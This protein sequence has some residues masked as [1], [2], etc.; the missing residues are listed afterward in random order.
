MDILNG[1]T[2]VYELETG[3]ANGILDFR[4]DGT[5]T[6][7]PRPEFV[8]FYGFE[9]FTYRISGTQNVAG[10]DLPVR[11][12]RAATVTINVRPVNDSPFANDF[13]F[14][15]SEPTDTN[16]NT[17]VTILAGASDQP[18]T[19][20]F[21]AVPH[22]NTTELPPWNE[23]EQQLAV[24]QITVTSSTG[25][26]VDVVDLNQPGPYVQDAFVFNPTGGNFVRIGSVTANVD[27]LSGSV[28]SVVFQPDDHYNEINPA[29]ANL[30]VDAFRFT[31]SDDGASTLPSGDPA[32]PQPAP[33]SY[34]ATA[35]VRVTP[36]NDRPTAGDDTYL[37]V[38]EDT[39]YDILLRNAGS[40]ILDNDLA[41]SL[42]NDDESG[43][44][45]DLVPG[46]PAGAIVNVDIGVLGSGV[47][48]QAGLSGTGYVMYSTTN[49][50]ARFGSNAPPNTVNAVAASHLLAVRFSNN[51]WQY[52]DGTIWH[53]FTPQPRV[54]GSANVPEFPGDRLIAQIDFDNNPLIPNDY[55]FTEFL[56]DSG[57]I[58]GIEL[59]YVADNLTITPQ[60]WNGL[61]HPSNFTIQAPTGEPAN[62][63]YVSD[64]TFPTTFFYDIPIVPPV[65]PSTPLP[66][67]GLKTDKGG[68]VFFSD[69][70]GKLIYRPPTDYYGPDSFEYFITDNDPTQP[71]FDSGRVSL[72]VNPVNDLPFAMDHSFTTQE[73]TQIGELITAAD[74]I[75]GARGHA[76]PQ[77]GEPDPND[78]TTIITQPWDE[79]N[80]DFDPS[81]PTPDN[82]YRVA[83]LVGVT[84][85]NGVLTTALG[86]EVRDV[87]R[88]ASDGSILDFRYFPPTDF[89]VDNPINGQDQDTFGY[90]LVDSGISE[91]LDGSTTAGSPRSA[92]GSI[93]VSVEPQNDEPAAADDFISDNPNGSWDRFFALQSQ[94]APGLLEEGQLLIPA[95]F[96]LANDAQARSTAG[97]ELAQI[98]DGQ[99]SIV[100]MTFTT[101]LGG[102]ITRTSGG[103]FLYSPPA[104][105]FGIDTFEYEIIDEG[106]ST[107]GG[108]VSN[109]PLTDRATVSILIQPVNDP[110]VAIDHSLSP[111]QENNPVD[112]FILFDAA[113][114]LVGALETDVAPLPQMPFDENEQELRVVAFEYTGSSGVQRVDVNNLRDPLSG[115]ILDDTLT[116]ITDSGRLD[117]EFLGGAFDKGRFTP[118]PDYNQRSP[119][120]PNE[121]FQYI[122][123]DDGLTSLGAFD[124][125]P[126]RVD[127]AMDERSQPA[128]VTLTVVHSNDAPEVIVDGV[129]A[130]NAEEDIL[131]VDQ[132]GATTIRF[133]D[134]ARPGT[135]T[136]LDELERE[137]VLFTLDTA[138][139]SIPAGL[140]DTDPVFG[141]D[142]T[143]SLFPTPDQIGN[144]CFCVERDG[145]ATDWRL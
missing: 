125:L 99:I 31:I 108:I 81:A 76:N 130:F 121:V 11:S 36:Q 124:G 133:A 44:V 72:L 78:P 142:G 21:G 62:F 136:A 4:A 67:D 64:A 137:E 16:T 32:V 102:N 42:S 95:A 8:D 18:N 77:Y 100:P 117:F 93:T 52:S 101:Q 145:S 129:L 116:I 43:G 50:F 49:V 53:D 123:A 19:L 126:A 10:I 54:P 134:I 13:S 38:L 85:V 33:E 110:P 87:R 2:P 114:L 105:A 40:G 28:V 27:A 115:Q 35:T 74:L 104:D 29:L 15:T 135:E 47:A 37:D 97:D 90:V 60:L 132:P 138:N 22:V 94:Q 119:F 122:I 68:D 56:F 17:A 39:P 107:T 144:S 96:V 143:V 14:V 127:E 59:G 103:D 109:D 51:Q 58:N 24:T 79:S 34:Q 57:S 9:T 75:A 70:E 71:K 7:T 5:F 55:A 89:N 12:D 30:F 46:Y 139:S 25:T 84:L 131:E 63:T 66:T 80:Q 118:N 128:N 91:L 61:P 86:G 41:G 141:T 73:D 120:A 111:G 48:V 20:L 92:L 3:V 6:Y 83:D 98:N 69:T 106:T 140:F 65:S 88:D 82:T 45:V 23:E 1:V 113:R 112:N 26:D